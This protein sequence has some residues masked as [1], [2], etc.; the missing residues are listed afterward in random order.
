[1]RFNR[2]HCHNVPYGHNDCRFSKAYIAKIVNQLEYVQVRIAK[3]DWEFQAMRYEDAIAAA[4][5]TRSST[6]TRPISDSRAPFTTPGT[7]R[8]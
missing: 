3:S 2:Q 8:R 1:M 4:P 6:A 7:R 5:D